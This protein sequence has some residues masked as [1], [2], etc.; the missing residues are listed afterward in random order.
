M[1]RSTVWTSG[2]QLLVQ[3]APGDESAVNSNERDDQASGYL[4][5]MPRYESDP[6]SRRWNV[7]LVRDESPRISLAGSV[8]SA[9]EAFQLASS[10]KRPLRIASQAWQQMVAADVAPGEV[11][12]GVTIT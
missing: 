6:K 3:S 11:P 12:G 9:T 10:R 1:R 5:V 8:A 4:H 2:A 7:F